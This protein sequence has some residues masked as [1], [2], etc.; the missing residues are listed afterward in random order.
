MTYPCLK[1][2]SIG[3]EKQHMHSY[4]FSLSCLVITVCAVILL[5]V[6]ANGIWDD[7]LRVAKTYGTGVVAAVIFLVHFYEGCFFNPPLAADK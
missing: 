7:Y 4:R 2:S 5:A 3:G 1:C 6:S